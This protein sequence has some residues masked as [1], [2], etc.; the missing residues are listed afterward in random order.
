MNVRQRQ[1]NKGLEEKKRISGTKSRGSDSKTSSEM[2]RRQRWLK[3][4]YLVPLIPLAGLFFIYIG[5]AND[6]DGFH[7]GNKAIDSLITSMNLHEPFHVVVID[8]GSTASRVLAFTFHE[9]MVNGQLILDDELF[10]ETKPGLSSFAKNPAGVEKSL[11]ILIQKA[12]SKIPESKWSQTPLTMKAT[13]GLRLLPDQIA[14]QILKECKRVF[15]AS[16]FNV[17]DDSV[18][19]ME[20]SD[21]GIFSWFTVNFLLG[22]FSK[23]GTS[24]EYSADTVAALDLGGG[25]TQVT[26][27]V[28]PSTVEHSENSSKSEKSIF[29]INA[30]NRN[31]SIYTRSFLGLGLMAARKAILTHPDNHMNKEKVPNLAQSSS[32]H[33]ELRA[34][35]VNPII[36]GAEWSY[37]GKNYLVKGPENGSFK[38][39]K[40]E[41]FGGSNEKRPIVRFSSCIEIVKKVVSTG[42]PRDIPN[43]S[44]HEIYA[45]SYYFE[46]MVEVGLVDPFKGGIITIGSI[47]KAALETCEYANTDQPFMCLDLTFIYT[48]LHD[49]FGLDDKSEFTLRKKVEGHE[50]SWGLGAAFSLIRGS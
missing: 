24:A 1:M 14:Q 21:E 30:F 19:I 28:E 36:T 37:G 26:F 15:N 9:S 35:C 44:Q 22:R 13:A 4:R 50:L 7:Y 45:F 3:I 2:P 12:K 42:T 39:I 8:A 11:N 43:F 16:G 32:E 29:N 10:Y 17:S 34:E 41:N 46:R 47:R 27:A 38:M 5:L 48:L 31:I 33:I 25:S 49:G 40:T 6:A 20:G 23:S 18:S